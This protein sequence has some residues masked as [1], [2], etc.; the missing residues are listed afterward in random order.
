MAN[1]SYTTYA[2]D[3]LNHLVSLT[4]YAAGDIIQSRFDYAYDTLG[5]MT[6]MTTLDGTW[7][8]SYDEDGQLTRALFAS[9]NPAISSQDLTYV[10]DAAGNRVRT[11]VNG[12]E[13]RY[14]VN[15]MNQ[16]VRAPAQRPVPMMSTATLSGKA[17]A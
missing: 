10:Y 3:T 15:N 16:Y 13:A 12:A 4:N 11:I 14:Y 7:T 17:T 6:S 2:Y 1:G 8:Y 5:L 9:T